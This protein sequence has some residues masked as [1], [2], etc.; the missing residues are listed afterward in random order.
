MVQHLG[1]YQFRYADGVLRPL[2]ERLSFE[3]GSIGVFTLAADLRGPDIYLDLY[4]RPDFAREFLRIVTDKVIGRYRWLRSLGADTNEGTYL[5]DDSA[6]ALSPWLYRDFVYPCNLRVAEAIGRPLRIH[7][8]APADHLLPFYREMEIASLDGFGWG[9]SLG[10]VREYLG[11][12]A[13]MSGNLEPALFAFGT[14]DD[15]YR[16]ATHALE[17]LGPCGGFTLMEG[18]NMVPEAK[19]E[20]IA[21]MLRA[22]EDF[23]LPV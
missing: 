22:S 3:W 13:T 14:P 17:I 10:K 15:V 23:G 16:A 18:A 21:A 2:P 9:T 1:D 12:Q 20:N 5:V 7:I 11:G 4:E 8:D 6:G 19:M